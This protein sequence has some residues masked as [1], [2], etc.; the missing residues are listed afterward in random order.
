MAFYPTVHFTGVT[1]QGLKIDGAY[2]VVKT[3]PDEAGKPKNQYTLL[4]SENKKFRAVATAEPYQVSVKEM[5]TMATLQAKANGQASYDDKNETEAQ[6]STRLTERFGFL[7]EMA[8]ACA[9]GQIRSLIVSGAAGVGKTFAVEKKM[10]EELDETDYDNIKGH[11]APLALYMLLHD[12]KEEGQVLIFD[13]CDDIFKEETNLNM[14]KAVLDTSLERKVNWRSNSK[15]LEQGN[16]PTQFVYRGTIVFISNIDFQKVADDGSSKM[17]QHFAALLNRSLYLDL[18]LRSRR[19]LMVRI[20]DVVDTE[21]MLKKIG[22][23]AAE[24]KAALNWM[25]DN[26]ENLRTVSLRTA[27]MVGGQIMSDKKRWERLCAI[28]LLKS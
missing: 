5:P 8:G 28:T 2:R 19:E 4:D 10:R 6:I 17:A 14:L 26:L 18:T 16:Y 25:N 23:S 20:R 21:K 12:Y 1:S 3:W 13:D 7:E 9:K 15:L 11:I 27:L 22:L 24:E